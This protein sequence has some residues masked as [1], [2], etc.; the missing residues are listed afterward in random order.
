M[1]LQRVGLVAILFTL[2][3]TLGAYPA[4]ACSQ[5]TNPPTIEDSLQEADIVIAAHIMN[6]R[7]A[8]EHKR[9]NYP[10]SPIEVTI[11]VDHVF[12][13]NGPPQIQF[14]DESS[15]YVDIHGALFWEE[16]CLSLFNQN[17]QD[18]YMI[19]STRERV[20]TSRYDIARVF[21]LGPAPAG[22]HYE[23]IAGRINRFLG[24]GTL[25]AA[26]APRRSIAPLLLMSGALLLVAAA[27]VRQRKFEAIA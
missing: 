11:K 25:P 18:M 3:L 27:L 22:E 19:M 20:I 15:L 23:L 9:G 13:G 16:S 1:T 4:S 6:W 10:Y 5:P 24:P 8:D 14:I 7:V 21:F 26:G 2:W 17:P 12:K